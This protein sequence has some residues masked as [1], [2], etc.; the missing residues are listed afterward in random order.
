MTWRG[1]SKS[2]LEMGTAFD[3]LKNV[4]AM[5][6]LGPPFE[7][8]FPRFFLARCEQRKIAYAIPLKSWLVSRGFHNGLESFPQNMLY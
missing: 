5:E 7:W 4:A 8:S 6:E 3:I 2:N 1:T